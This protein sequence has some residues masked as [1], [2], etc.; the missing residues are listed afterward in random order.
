MSKNNKVWQT[1]TIGL[2]VVVVALAMFIVISEVKAV[3]TQ[4]EAQESRITTLEQNIQTIK[5]SLD[6]KGFTD[7]NF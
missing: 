2:L 5:Q 6:A 1:I 7:L 4:Q 3:G